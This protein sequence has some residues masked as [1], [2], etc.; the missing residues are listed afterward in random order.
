ML[1]QS[2]VKRKERKEKLQ[3]PMYVAWL[4]TYLQCEDG[5]ADSADEGGAVA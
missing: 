1:M 5:S 3:C 2:D 4:C